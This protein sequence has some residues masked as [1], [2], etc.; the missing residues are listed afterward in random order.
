MI[1]PYIRTTPVTVKTFPVESVV[2]ASVVGM[3]AGVSVA[4]CW[5]VA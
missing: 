5:G 3:A 4:D 1:F 2:I